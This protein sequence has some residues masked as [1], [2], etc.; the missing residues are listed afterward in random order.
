MGHHD[1]DLATI[2][3]TACIMAAQHPHTSERLQLRLAAA[4]DQSNLP[5]CLHAS[6]PASLPASLTCARIGVAFA[7]GVQRECGL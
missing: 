1:G 2:F 3:A 6:L 7:S 4:Q 5:A